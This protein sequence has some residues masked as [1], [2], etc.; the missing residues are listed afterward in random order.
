MTQFNPFVGSVLQST[1]VQRQQSAEKSSQIRRT[2][3]LQK[4]IAAEDEQLKEQ[5]ESSQ[6]LTPAREQRD[7]DEHP[8]HN[9]DDEDDD[10]VD[11]T[12]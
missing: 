9:H 7:T 10:H 1:L 12:A 6:E 3:Q 2:Q 5:V 11:L 8:K 4:N